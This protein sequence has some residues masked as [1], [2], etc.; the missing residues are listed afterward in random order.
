MVNSAKNYCFTINNPTAE[1]EAHLST[2]EVGYIVYQVERVTTEHIQGYVQFLTRKT[3]LAA[4]RAICAR[5]HIEISR[6]S[7]ADNEAYCTKPD[8]R[9]RGP[10]RR[11]T[12]S[13]QGQR[14]DISHFVAKIKSGAKDA[15]IIN[16][17]PLEFLK[18]ARQIDRVRNAFQE[19]RNWEMEVYVYWGRSGSGKTRRATEE[20]GASIYYVSKG[21][22]KQTTWW[23]GYNGQTSVILDD[24]YGWLPWSFI[25]R[26]LD[27]YPFAV[28]IKGGTVNFTSKK[29][30]ITSNSPPQN[31]Y[32]NIPNNDMTPLLRRITQ[33]NEMN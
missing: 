28:Q 7:P 27:R 24:F 1:E 30:F 29:I 12:L 23:D 32:K 13:Q 21:D 15:D 18:Y 6:G 25:L 33:I 10:V 14:N 16:E 8:S 5:A 9:V 4:K 11:G 22:D 20:A 31:W 17:Y 19:Q 2:I 26:L 3:L